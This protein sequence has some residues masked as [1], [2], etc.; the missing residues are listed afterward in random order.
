MVVDFYARSDVRAEID[1]YVSSV[2]TITYL[3]L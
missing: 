1:G 3:T 2:K